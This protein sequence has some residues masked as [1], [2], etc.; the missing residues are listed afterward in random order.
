[1]SGYIFCLSRAMNDKMCSLFVFVCFAFC[2]SLA[3]L[4][5]SLLFDPVHTFVLSP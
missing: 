2:R 3:S 5:S 4:S 1:M